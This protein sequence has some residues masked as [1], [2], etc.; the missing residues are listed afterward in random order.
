MIETL[1]R[2]RLLNILE[3]KMSET[4]M[5]RVDQ[6]RWLLNNGLVTDE[7]K[8]N[9]YIYGTLVN[10]EVKAVEVSLDVENKK[11]HYTLY[12]SN[13]FLKDYNK[14]NELV[15]TESI[16]GLF[17][18]RR[19]LKKHGNLNIGGILKSFVSDYCGPNWTVTYELKDVKEYIDGPE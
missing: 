4:L 2:K 12:F 18:L 10:K 16:F 7:A 14:F 6:Q 19:I 1:L 9:V 11:I 15:G 13:S 17:R 8:N 5:E 3:I